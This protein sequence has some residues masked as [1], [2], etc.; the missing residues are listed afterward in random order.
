[1]EF[2][3]TISTPIYKEL[4]F[5]HLPLLQLLIAL[6]LLSAVNAECCNLC[7]RR[8]S[9]DWLRDGEWAILK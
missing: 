7:Y 2:V 4:N 8:S 3:H 6:S 1:M 9:D 5:R